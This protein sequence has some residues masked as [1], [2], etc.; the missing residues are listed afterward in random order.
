MILRHGRDHRDAIARE[1]RKDLVGA[2][3]FV[4]ACAANDVPGLLTAANFLNAETVDGWRLAMMG[5]M[6]LPAVTDEIR[7]AFLNVWIEA[8]TLPASIGNRPVLARALR[9]LL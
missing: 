8:K 1:R 4:T 7:A 6:R 9:V 2:R 5:V 3:A